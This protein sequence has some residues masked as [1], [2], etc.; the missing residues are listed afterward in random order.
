MNPQPNQA[1]EEISETTNTIKE[2]KKSEEKP[3]YQKE[4]EEGKRPG[5]NIYKSMETQ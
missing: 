3:E 1:A 4:K 5:G 2:E